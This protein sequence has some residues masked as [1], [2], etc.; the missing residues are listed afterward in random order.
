MLNLLNLTNNLGNVICALAETLR[1]GCYKSKKQD[2]WFLR[3]EIGHITDT[4]V[5]L[6]PAGT[7]KK[8][9]CIKPFSDFSKHLQLGQQFPTAHG[10]ISD[11]FSHLP[12][13][14]LGN[15][16]VTAVRIQTWNGAQNSKSQLQG[17]EQLSGTMGELGKWRQGQGHCRWQGPGSPGL[18]WLS[19][20]VAF[21]QWAYIY[22]RQMV[23]TKM[24]AT[25]KLTFARCRL[26]LRCCHFSDAGFASMSPMK[27]KSKNKGSLRVLCFK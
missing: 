1:I 7:D 13:T 5:S 17:L 15:S 2:K 21:G 27:R 23:S 25:R 16:W 18:G 8:S 22:G 3:T 9:I 4:F 24:E 6:P 11:V 20:R 14:G 12:F 26:C 19:L 10:F